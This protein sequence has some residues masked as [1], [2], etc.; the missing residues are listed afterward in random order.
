MA[1]HLDLEEQEQLDQLKAFWKQYGNL[2]TWALIAV[3]AAFAAWNGWNW[4]QRDQSVKAG[5]M[6]DELESAAG[7]GDAE[8][9]A[10]VFADMKSRFPRTA[11]TQEV[12]LLSDKSG[13]LQWTLGA[14]YYD[15]VNQIP[16]YTLGANTIVSTAKS[17]SIAGYGQATYAI[18]PGTK[19]TLGARYTNEKSSIDGVVLSG[20]APR[21]G[22]Q[23]H[24]SQTFNEL[25]WRAALDQQLTTNAMVYASVSRGF[26]AGFFNVSSFGGFANRTQNPPVLPEYLTAYEIGAKTDFLDHHLRVNVSG[27]IY[28]Y[29]NLVQSVFTSGSVSSINAAAAN[30]KGIDFEIVARPIP[31]LTLSLDGSYIDGHYGSYPNAPNYILLPTSEVI[32]PIGAQAFDAAGNKIVNAPDWTYTF[33]VSHTLKTSVGRFDTTGNLSYRG[34]S[35][36]DPGNRIVLPTRYVVN[37]TERWTA[38]NS[39][40][41]TELWVKNLFDKRYD[42]GVAIVVPL[43]LVG[44][45]AP[46]RTYGVTVGV[47]F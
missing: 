1:T 33:T 5:A 15:A 42:N 9:A 29:R 14:F 26:N 24:D 22:T 6:F 21:P 8:R 2:V 32:L 12:Q 44:S 45:P 17:N 46:P 27:Y 38:S 25:T 31:S 20:G 19:L 41:F 39:H 35:F 4:W 11:F 28:N 37:L 23:G 3:L 7:T 16:N 47:S 13:P 36:V 34:K 43:G 40:L 18:T 10:R 30:I